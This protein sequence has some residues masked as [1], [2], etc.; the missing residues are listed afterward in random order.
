MLWCAR[1]SHVL[2]FWCTLFFGPI[3]SW[4]DSVTR[5]LNCSHCWGG[6]SRQW[7][8]GSQIC[9][10]GPSQTYDCFP[11]AS[12]LQC[13]KL[14]CR[15]SQSCDSIDQRR[16]WSVHHPAP[17]PP[18]PP[19]P[20][21][22]LWW[23]WR[24]WCLCGDRWHSQS[25]AIVLNWGASMLSCTYLLDRTVCWWWW[26]RSQHRNT[27]WGSLSLASLRHEVLIRLSSC[28]SRYPLSH[29]SLPAGMSLSLVGGRGEGGEGGGGGSGR[30]LHES[31]D[32]LVESVLCL[33]TV[34]K[35]GDVYADDCNMS[36]GVEWQASFIN[37]SLTADGRSG[38]CPQSEVLRANPTPCILS[39]SFAFQLQKNVYPHF[40][41]AIEPSSAS[42]VSLRAATSIWYLPSSLAMRAVLLSG[43]EEASRSRKVC[44]F[45][46]PKINFFVDSYRF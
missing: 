45:H 38:S 30:I 11:A 13:Q 26:G 12:V 21:A 3:V 18:P 44:T 36:G 22:S 31:V 41:S 19:R 46:A 29:C 10:L 37:R 28:C 24:H 32:F 43:L 27:T 2:M 7:S 1:R 34:G 15:I 8:V 4:A 25:D 40:G 39:S 42:L 5:V 35:S 20:S 23:F 6:G 14:G 33:V 17:P 16:R 9:R